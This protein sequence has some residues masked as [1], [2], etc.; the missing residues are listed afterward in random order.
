LIAIIAMARKVII[1]DTKTVDT[2]VIFG[3]A[4]MFW[5]LLSAIFWC[6]RLYGRKNLTSDD[7]GEYSG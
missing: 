2:F 1:L 5:R 7:K 4:M 6:G 3:I